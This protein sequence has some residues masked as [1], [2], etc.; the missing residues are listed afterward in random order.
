MSIGSVP[1]IV[2]KARAQSTE[3]ET[4]ADVRAPFSEARAVRLITET[5]NSLPRL[6][7][8]H[9]LNWTPNTNLTATFLGADYIGPVLVEEAFKILRGRGYFL[10]SCHASWQEHNP[11][12]VRHLV[13][14]LQESVNAG[15]LS[16]FL[17][18]RKRLFEFKPSQ[19][20]PDTTDTQVVSQGAQ[21]NRLSSLYS[22]F[23]NVVRFL[24]IAKDQGFVR[25]NQFSIKGIE[26]EIPKAS[27]IDAGAT[28]NE[29]RQAVD[30][31]ALCYVTKVLE[32]QSASSELVPVISTEPK[33]FAPL[34]AFRSWDWDDFGDAAELAVETAKLLWCDL[35]F[36]FKGDSFPV[37]PT[38]DLRKLNEVYLRMISMLNV[39]SRWGKEAERDGGEM[40][41]D[42]QMPTSREPRRVRDR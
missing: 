33:V 28:P 42:I 41:V 2:A 17:N 19:A 39:L 18:Q 14:A 5:I 13:E 29:I 7:G 35:E 34:S 25:N 26:V 9:G 22:L 21:Y 11:L 32:A 23:E 4:L 20:V 8:W 31:L 16:S 15:L 6:H 27:I 40:H 3:R 12:R 24:E 1:P 38:T 30:A 10:G 36:R 37:S